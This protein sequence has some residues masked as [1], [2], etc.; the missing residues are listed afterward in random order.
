MTYIHAALPSLSG[1]RVGTFYIV[2]PAGIGNRGRLMYLC[3]CDKCH[4]LQKARA[5]NLRKGRQGRWEPFCKGC[6]K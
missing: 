5:Q 1:L 2:G 3:R 6:G 4:T